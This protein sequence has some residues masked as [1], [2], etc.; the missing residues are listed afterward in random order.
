M[1]R[2]CD[3]I[4]KS[5]PPPLRFWPKTW[6]GRKLYTTYPRYHLICLSHISQCSMFA[7]ASTQFFFQKLKMEYVSFP[8]HLS[9]IKNVKN[10]LLHAV[11]SRKEKR[12]NYPRFPATQRKFSGHKKHHMMY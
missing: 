12:Q 6:E 7:S 1:S 9:Q 2:I 10:L 8:H 3:F 11:A 4:Q 5:C